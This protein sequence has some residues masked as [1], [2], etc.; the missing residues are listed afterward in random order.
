[1]SYLFF[2]GSKIY[3]IVFLYLCLSFFLY[4]WLSLQ[5]NKNLLTIYYMWDTEQAMK[6]EK[7]IK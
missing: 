1:M 7:E 5:F 6:V 4:H 3:Y 2:W